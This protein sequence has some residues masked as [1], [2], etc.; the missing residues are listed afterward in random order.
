MYGSAGTA[1]SGRYREVV[2][3]SV[4]TVLTK[5][6]ELKINRRIDG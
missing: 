6:N 1:K 3:T 2:V 5:M 4:S